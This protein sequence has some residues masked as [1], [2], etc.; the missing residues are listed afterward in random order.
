GT[1]MAVPDADAAAT[2]ATA[3]LP[4]L[5]KAE[6]VTFLIRVAQATMAA[7]R[8]QGPT[9][10]TTQQQQHL[11]AL[12]QLYGLPGLSQWCQRLPANHATHVWWAILGPE[13]V[14]AA[15]A[16]AVQTPQTGGAVGAAGATASSRAASATVAAQRDPKPMG[17]SY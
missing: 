2:A 5:R 11:A 8:E 17:Q 12:E 7:L 9:R 6:A 14:A 15:R 13:R 10:L 16:A 4:D 1:Q 3:H